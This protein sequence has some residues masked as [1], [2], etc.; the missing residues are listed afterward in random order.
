MDIEISWISHCSLNSN[1][2]KKQR[3][4]KLS[5]SHKD[6]HCFELLGSTNAHDFSIEI[7]KEL[8]WKRTCGKTRISII[9]PKTNEIATF[10]PPRIDVKTTCFFVF[11]ENSIAS[12]YLWKIIKKHDISEYHL[13]LRNSNILTSQD[14]SKDRPRP[15]KSPQGLTRTL[16]GH[17]QGPQGCPR[18]CQETPKG[19]QGTYK[20]PSWTPKA[21]QASQKHAPSTSLLFQVYPMHTKSM[22]R[23]HVSSLKSRQRSPCVSQFFTVS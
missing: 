5:L 3:K 7:L 20:G 4:Q 6:F 19:P 1:Q 18:T 9:I 8:H 22:P 15:P 12:K 2:S 10:W 13:K 23:A 21:P 17:S 14:W 11:Y 16:P